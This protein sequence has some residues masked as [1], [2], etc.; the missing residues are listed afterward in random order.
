M[1]ELVQVVPWPPRFQSYAAYCAELD[2]AVAECPAF[3]E[4]LAK[5]QNPENLIAQKM[6]QYTNEP[7]PAV[8][9]HGTV[10]EYKASFT[11]DMERQL[12]AKHAK[13]RVAELYKAEYER[14]V[15]EAREV[16]DAKLE[17]VLAAFAKA[18]GFSVEEAKRLW[19]YRML[20]LAAHDKWPVPRALD[21][22]YQ[23]AK[24]KIQK[25][26]RELEAL[27]KELEEARLYPFAG[28]DASRTA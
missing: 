12:R 19:E 9:W 15:E 11:H 18:Q 4:W 6:Q 26:E 7:V 27:D 17:D 8:A 23:A 10:E 22:P 13:R 1:S 5:S 24:K 20:H 16:F 25:A 2:K 14:H 3:G 28:L 21:A